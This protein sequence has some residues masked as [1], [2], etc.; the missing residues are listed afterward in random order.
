MNPSTALAT[1]LVDE[2]VRGGVRQ[3]VVSPGSRSS[4]LA[5][6]LYNADAEGRLRLH[7]RVDERS[8]GFLALGLAK[9][10]GVPAVVLTTSGTAAANLHPAVTESD[11]A[12]VPLVVLTADRPPELRATGANQTIDQLKL[13]GRSVRFFAEVGTPDE[14]AG[15]NA[16]WRGLAS[17]ALAESTGALSGRPGPVHLNLAFREP[18]LP[19]STDAWP[20]SLDGRAAGQ[21]WTRVES[22]P[23]ARSDVMLPPR[24]L[25][26]VGDCVPAEGR[27]ALRLAEEHGW[28]VVSE[29]T[30]NANSGPQA[31]STGGWVLG[32]QQW[33]SGNRPTSI[34]VV[35]RPTLSRTVLEA[36]RDPQVST[37]VVPSAGQW[38][39]STRSAAHVLR[40]LPRAQGHLGAD[41][42]WQASW[43]SA[44][45]A[46]RST[47]DAVLDARP[48]SEQTLVRELHGALPPDALLVAGSSLPIRH[49]FLAAR[50]REGVTTV[51][52]RGA[53]G[54]DGTI[55][56]ALGAAQTW[57][58]GGGGPAVALVGDLTFLHDSNGLFVEQGQ[59]VRLTVVV[60]NNDGGGIFELLEQATGTDRP[61]FERLF[62]TPTGADL[63]ALCG[64]SGTPFA[65]VADGGELCAAVTD[66]R[67]GIQVVEVR[68][69]RAQTAATQAEV[70]KAVSAVLASS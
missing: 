9:V 31:I 62:G 45:Q 6:A 51:A 60:V 1:V 52:N 47:V 49:L 35:G 43:K 21:A 69:E 27:A 55:S 36:L 23:P 26:V 19:V 33:W 7:V 25:V 22:P 32:Q 29:P 17:R 67:A 66:P 65:R 12:G 16:Y 24:T 39:D 4:S 14:S 68:A 48:D 2:L 53:A 34:L 3:A 46:A 30:G 61:M 54:I 59:D 64:A 8:A 38:S 41:T 56:T 18:F 63:A 70:A 13:F 15:Q 37:Y 40:S 11:L 20:E 58:E 10:S 44:E 57:Q 42:V 28:P 50:A 5:L